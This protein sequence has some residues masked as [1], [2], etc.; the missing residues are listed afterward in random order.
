MLYLLGLMKQKSLTIGLVI[1]AY[2]ESETIEACLTA[3]LQQSHPF[4]EIIVVDNNSTDD[5][6][7]RVR[8]FPG[9]RVITEQKQGVT[10]A[11]DTGFDIIT[12]DV[13]GR[14][15]ADSLLDPDW[16]EQVLR[17]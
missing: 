10:Y 16:A 17:V 6:V 5:T 2:N 13:I 4:D 3:A 11:R 8:N 12:T 7:E 15:D 14:I 1:P 9:V